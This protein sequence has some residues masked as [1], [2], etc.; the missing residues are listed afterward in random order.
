MYV[1]GRLPYDKIML[2]I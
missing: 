1:F 2:T